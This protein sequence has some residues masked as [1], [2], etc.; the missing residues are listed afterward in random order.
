MLYTTEMRRTCATTSINWFLLDPQLLRSYKISTFTLYFIKQKHVRRRRRL[1]SVLS[2]V[3]TKGDPLCFSTKIRNAYSSPIW[4]EF[5]FISV[6]E[7]LIVR[8][9]I[10]K[11]RW[12]NCSSGRK[13]VASTLA[14]C[15]QMCDS[16]RESRDFLSFC[17]SYVLKGMIT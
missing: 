13:P 9:Q 1:P 7:L 10:A 6:S 4:P 5:L 3:H 15:C 17:M 8:S 12:Q 11:K 14:S 16:L 2:R